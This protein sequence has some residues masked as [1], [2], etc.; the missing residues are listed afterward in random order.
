ME[1]RFEEYCAFGY[2]ENAVGEI[3]FS[4]PTKR[5]GK[6]ATRQLSGLF[7]GALK[8]GPRKTKKCCHRSGHVSDD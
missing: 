1:K 5:T 7:R 3:R 4:R 6:I 8:K 2:I